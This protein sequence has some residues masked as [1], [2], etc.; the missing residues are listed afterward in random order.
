MSGQVSTIVPGVLPQ[1]EAL[2]AGHRTSVSEFGSCSFPVL[3]G[4]PIGDMSG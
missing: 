1:V 2:L 3:V 4:Y